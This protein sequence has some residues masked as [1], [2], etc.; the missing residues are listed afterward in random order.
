MQ[1]DNFTA[2]F[3]SQNLFQPRR[4]AA[5]CCRAKGFSRVIICFE[6]VPQPKITAKNRHGYIRAYNSNLIPFKQ[7][8]AVHILVVILNVEFNKF[9]KHIAVDFGTGV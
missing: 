7:T 1:T 4:A 5:C 3:F 9:R 8:V 6:L 2:K